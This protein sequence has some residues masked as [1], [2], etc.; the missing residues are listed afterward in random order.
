MDEKVIDCYITGG[1][2]RYMDCKKKEK[3]KRKCRAE[4]RLCSI[5]SCG[6]E[7]LSLGFPSLGTTLRRWV[8]PFVVRHYPLSLGFTLRRW[9]LPSAVGFCPS[10]CCYASLSSLSIPMSLLMSG[11]VVVVGVPSPWNVPSLSAGSCSD[12]AVVVVYI[13]VVVVSVVRWGGSPGRM[14]LNPSVGL[15]S[16]S[17][18]S[19]PLEAFPTLPLSGVVLGCHLDVV[20]AVGLGLLKS[21]LSTPVLGSPLPDVVCVPPTALHPNFMRTQS[22]CSTRVRV[23]KYVSL[24]FDLYHC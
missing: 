16:L 17:L 10:S 18:G 9:A 3:Q 7:A 22:L 13:A 14:V 23:A 4:P 21:S 2:G 12:I 11:I 5:V 24:S 20:R 19:L 15:V 6:L 1:M 8:P